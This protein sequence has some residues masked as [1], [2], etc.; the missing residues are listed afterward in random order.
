MGL[1]WGILMLW[2]ALFKIIRIDLFHELFTNH[3][4]L[5]PALATAH[6]LGIVVF[7]SQQKIFDLAT[8]VNQALMKFLLVMLVLVAVIFL[9]ALP[10]TGLAPLWE[11]RTGSALILWLQVLILFFLNGV[12]QC[13]ET[14]P[15]APAL[16]RAISI[17]VAFLPIYSAI[18]FYG[19]QL[20]IEQ[21][22]WTVERCW[23]ILIWALLAL[24][25]IG[26]MALICRYRERWTAHLGSVNIGMGLV[27][28]AT[29]LLAN[30]P[31]L[32]FR[33]I[34]V[35]SQLARLESNELTLQNFD[36]NYF[37]YQL[38][39]PGYDAL[40]AIKNGSASGDPDIAAKIDDLYRPFNERASINDAESLQR[41]LAVWPR[42][43]TL[44][45]KLLDEVGDW[46][47][48][49]VSARVSQ[50]SVFV[51]DLNGDGT[52]EY[53]VSTRVDTLRVS[54]L[55]MPVSEGWERI[56]IALKGSATDAELAAS[57]ESGDVHVVAPQW[58]DLQ[59]GKLR[60]RVVQ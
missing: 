26:Y 30:S 53:L 3:W 1:F 22:G 4:F 19:M 18:A 36:Y 6:G 28:A 44:P 58:R 10:F 46:S 29:L 15:Y 31:L 52:D 48:K 57:L 42:G 37:R 56:D 8:R 9:C 23:G 13:D 55:F 39:R 35:A 45:P 34:S 25:S 38:A 49:R 14:R 21:Y 60:M 33:K 27:L 7:R 12:Y 24:F 2:G 41:S 17:G 50:T 32:D 16:H 54:A 47:N 43:A 20:R 5:Y 59:V 11:T 51:V 40:Q